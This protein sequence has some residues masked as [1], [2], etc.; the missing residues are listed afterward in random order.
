MEPLGSRSRVVPAAEDVA[1]IFDFW[2]GDEAAG[3]GVGRGVAVARG[4]GRVGIFFR[5]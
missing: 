3:R 5:V 4:Q 1:P 2:V